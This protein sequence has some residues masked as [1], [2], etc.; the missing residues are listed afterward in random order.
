M[1]RTGRPRSPTV[2]DPILAGAL[3]LVVAAAAAVVVT[4]RAL[5][6]A[7]SSRARVLAFC[8]ATSVFAGSVTVVRYAPRFVLWRA[9][10][11]PPALRVA[12]E[13]NR[14]SDALRQYD[15]LSVEIATPT[16]RVIRWRLLLPA[17]GRLVGLPPAG[18]LALAH[19]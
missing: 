6:G 9:L 18:Y 12:P 10:S 13:V 15:D 16:N 2:I 1:R 19:L 7:R 5:G 11:V 4:A 3:A 8:A 17:T 14:A